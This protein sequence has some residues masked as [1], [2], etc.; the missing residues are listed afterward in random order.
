MEILVLCVATDDRDSPIDESEI[1][2]LLEDSCSRE[3]CRGTCEELAAAD[4]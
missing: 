3:L 1:P 2:K 4:E